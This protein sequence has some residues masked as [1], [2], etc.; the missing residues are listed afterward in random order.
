MCRAV[1]HNFKPDYFFYNLPLDRFHIRYIYTFQKSFIDKLFY[2]QRF[3]V[4]EVNGSVVT[5][6]IPTTKIEIYKDN[7]DNHD[8]VQEYDEP[9]QEKLSNYLESTPNQDTSENYNNIAFLQINDEP[10]HVT[11]T[12]SLG[13][14]LNNFTGIQFKGM[15]THLVISNL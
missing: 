8:L 4:N 15:R 11:I 14:R 3:D 6:I 5:V 13:F 1:H 2:R 7:N 12:S 10:T 9:K